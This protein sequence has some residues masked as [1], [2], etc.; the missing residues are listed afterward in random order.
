[1]NLGLELDL[2]VKIQ[3]Q[4]KSQLLTLAFLVIATF[5]SCEPSKCFSSGVLDL[6]RGLPNLVDGLSGSVLYHFT[7]LRSCFAAFGDVFQGI[8]AVSTAASLLGSLTLAT[9]SRYT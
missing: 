7:S 1:V 9:A 8:A 3:L 6:T 4:S 5:A 2:D